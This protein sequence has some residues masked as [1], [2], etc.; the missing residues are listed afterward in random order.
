MEHT[1]IP[2]LGRLYRMMPALCLLALF[3]SCSS[4]EHGAA[5]AGLNAHPLQFYITLADYNGGSVTRG[6]LLSSLDE[7]I[8][9]S[10]FS[11]SAAEEWNEGLRPEY[12]Y[13]EEVFNNEDRWLTS[14]AYT[15]PA[16]GSKM[17]V[18]AYYP[19][20]DTEDA[21]AY[22]ASPLQL[23]GADVQGTP[24]LT[25]TVPDLVEQ[26]TDLMAG[27]TSELV[28][29]ADNE[30]ALPLTVS[31]LLS[32][33]QLVAGAVPASEHGTITAVT[34]RGV[35]GKGTYTYDQGWEL[36]RYDPETDYHDYSQPLNFIMDGTTGRI[37]NDDE[38]TFLMLPQQ[39]PADAVLEV[40]YQC[41]GSTHTLTHS[42]NGKEW[43]QG[44]IARYIVNIESLQ[45]M[46]LT[47]QIVDWDEGFTM[48]D[49]RSTS[50]AVVD[51]TANLNDWDGTDG[52]NNPLDQSLS[53]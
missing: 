26:Q 32:G 12:F 37:I 45:R 35:W 17:R 52:D 50:H 3:P 23:S 1:N 46:T 29:A 24:F 5:E 19:F 53:N 13:N 44:R 43:K 16:V 8:G 2:L 39:L 41:G 31:H 9:M 22:A 18:F 10:A 47:E 25:Y 38:A 21:E 20:V 34:L 7:S 40:S 27:C 4:E 28:I 36:L 33:V 30:A 49:G 48:V 51:N 42:L 15:P 14:G 6:A 11:Y